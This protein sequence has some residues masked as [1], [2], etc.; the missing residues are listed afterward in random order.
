MNVSRIQRGSFLDKKDIQLPVYIGKLVYVIKIIP[1]S[2]VSALGYIPEFR[3]RVGPFGPGPHFALIGIASP[4]D[5]APYHREI[6]ASDP[7]LCLPPEP[8]PRTPSLNETMP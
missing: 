3:E 6:N 2:D 4:G 7:K 1:D 8:H 5:P